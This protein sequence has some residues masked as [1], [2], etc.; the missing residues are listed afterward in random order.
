[1]WFEIT[2]RQWC[3]A[4]NMSKFGGTFAS[5]GGMSLVLANVK[6]Q[7]SKNI[8]P[9]E[10]KERCCLPHWHLTHKMMDHVTRICSNGHI[11]GLVQ[12]RSNYYAVFGQNIPKLGEVSK[13]LTFA[14]SLGY[15]FYPWQPVTSQCDEQWQ[16]LFEPSELYPCARLTLSCAISLTSSLW[17]VYI[18]NIMYIIYIY[19]SPLLRHYEWYTY[20]YTYTHIYICVCVCIHT[21]EGILITILWLKDTFVNGNQPVATW[22]HHYVQKKWPSNWHHH[23]I[24]TSTKFENM[25]IQIGW[26]RM[27][28]FTTLTGSQAPHKTSLPCPNT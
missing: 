18:Y 3:I 23:F 28:P 11:N 2:D 22:R 24:M 1:M 21:Q 25:T 8:F 6:A 7:F 13:L 27:N 17:V 4:E 14:Q 9:V 26:H 12:D 10:I 5:P 19:L 20:I 16:V 15:F